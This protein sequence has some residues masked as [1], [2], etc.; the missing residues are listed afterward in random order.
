MNVCPSSTVIYRNSFIEVT[1]LKLFSFKNSSGLCSNRFLCLSLLKKIPQHNAATAVLH[2]RDAVLSMMK[3]DLSL[4][5]FSFSFIQP[6]YLLHMF[7]EE[8]PNFY[9]LKP[10]ACGCFSGCTGC[11]MKFFILKR[12][13][14]NKTSGL[15][16]MFQNLQIL[17]CIDGAFPQV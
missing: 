4:M 9:F 12:L 10:M 3:V 1:Q 14:L 8:I 6:Q 2:C 11:I 7:G 16:E 17:F 5:I 13:S 15:E